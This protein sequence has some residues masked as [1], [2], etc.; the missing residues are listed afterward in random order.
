MGKCTTHHVLE[1]LMFIEAA[2][3]SLM[4]ELVLIFLLLIINEWQKFGWM[5]TRNIC[6]NAFQRGT[7]TLTLVSLETLHEL[8]FEFQSPIGDLS[9]QF[10]IKKR[11]A[12]KP[13][14]YF[15]DVVAPGELLSRL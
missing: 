2:V 1:L 14:R 11:Q 6:T 10:Y 8:S 15:F 5:N 13:F 4:L 12:C 9:Y 3:H 7:T